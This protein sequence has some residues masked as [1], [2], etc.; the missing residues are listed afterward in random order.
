MAGMRKQ[1]EEQLSKLPP[2]RRR[3]VEEMMKQKM[4]G[5]AGAGPA[6]VKPAPTVY[7]KTASGQQVGRWSCD[8]YAGTRDQQKVSEVCTV[9]YAELG[10]EPADLQVFQQMAEMVK[11]FA[12]PEMESM[13]RLG[14]SSEGSASTFHGIPVQRISFRN[15][16]P[17]S[18]SQVESVVRGDIDHALFEVPEGFKKIATPNLSAPER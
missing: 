13:L 1:M 15:G 4:G 16:A 9:G 7:S 3:L 10:V 6:A 5:M 8:K 12:P 14:P 11:G 18:Q 17:Y 2:D